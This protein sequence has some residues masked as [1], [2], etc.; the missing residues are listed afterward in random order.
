MTSQSGI[1]IDVYA[2]KLFCEE[3][4]ALLSFPT[5][6]GV[7]R[8]GCSCCGAKH[9]LSDYNGVVFN[10]NTTIPRKSKLQQLQE[11]LEEFKSTE[12]EFSIIQEQCPKCG[13]HERKFFTM[14]LRSADE[15]QTVFYECMKCGFKERVNN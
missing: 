11:Q 8:W 10:F 7:N 13:H 5:E 9:H 1:D 4:G 3:C 12:Q 15:G 14:Q 2:S 6:S